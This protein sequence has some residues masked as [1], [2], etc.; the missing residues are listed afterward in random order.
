MYRMLEDKLKI[1]KN[2]PDRKPLLLRGA[3]QVGKSYTVEKFAKE[4]FASVALVNFEFDRR[5]IGC[6]ETMDP[7]Q[8]INKI[9]LLTQ[10]E[11]SIGQTL[12]FLDEIQECPNAI[13]ALRYFKEKMPKLHVIGAGSL[14]EFTLNDPK[15]RMPVGRIQSLYL[16][17]CSFQEFL[18]ACGDQKLLDC[19]SQVT[20]QSG[21]DRVI[22]ELL[23]EKLRLYF[24]VG[25]MPEAIASYQKNKN[26]NLC[27]QVH[28]S[29]LDTYRND[30]GKYNR[31]VRSDYLQKLF[32]K[33]PGLVAQHF[34]YV[35]IDSHAQSR[36]IKPALAALI[37]AGLLYPIYHSSASGLPLNATLNEKKFKLLFLDIGLVKYAS[38]LEVNI[39]LNDS[40]ML[41]N[42]G[43]LAEQF[44]GQELLAYALPD[45][46]ATLYYWE[47]EKKGSGAEVDFILQTEGKLFPVEVKSGKTGRLKSLQLFLDEKKQNYGIQISQR[48]LSFHHRILSIPLYMIH[49]LPRLI[50]LII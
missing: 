46:R 29:L 27:R 38:G 35:A 44:V 32:D 31:H 14:L 11:I 5:L 16:K 7:E 12:L 43:A 49:E 8:I 19:L 41:L 48:Q 25:G 20:L 30:F 15:F 39:M 37:D 22:H 40:L 3:R 42:Q 33:A 17:P 36:D 45:E 1:W 4:H 21:V 24:F 28:A 23:L 10:Q 47:R 18:M 50:N 34:K 9:S 13:L 2:Q 26:L 6:F